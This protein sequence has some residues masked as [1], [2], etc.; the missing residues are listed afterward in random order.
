MADIKD[1]VKD[2]IDTMGD[3][4]KEYV[5]RSAGAMQHGQESAGGMMHTAMDKAKDLAHGAKDM[6][7]TAMD[8]AKDAAV[9]AKDMA[10]TAVDKAKEWAGSAAEGMSHAKDA[11]MEYASEAYEKS[12]EVAQNVGKEVTSFV[13]RYPIPSLLIGL[14]VGFLLGRALRSSA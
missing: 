9:A 5:E 2:R 12:A 7:G 8:K 13:R 6:A 1:R 4:S 11:A 14:G 3:K 10:G